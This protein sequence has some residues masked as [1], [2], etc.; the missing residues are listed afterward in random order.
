MTS[1]RMNYRSRRKMTFS[2]QRQLSR[3]ANQK[4]LE[5]MINILNYAGKII[6]ENMLQSVLSFLSISQKKKLMNKCV[7]IAEKHRMDKEKIFCDYLDGSETLDESIA[8]AFKNTNFKKIIYNDITN[9]L[10]KLHD[11]IKP[12]QDNDSL[13]K[14]LEH[15]AEIFNLSPAET[16]L[17]LFLYIRDHHRTVDRAFDEFCEFLDI[18][19]Y[20]NYIKNP[21]SLSIVTG[22]EKNLISKAISSSSNMEK[23]GVIN[24]DKELAGEINQFLHGNSHKPMTQKYFTEYSKS[25]IP[26]EYHTIDKKHIQ[27]VKMLL[28]HKSPTQ[29][30]NI[31]LYGKPGT[32][33]S[34]FSRSLGKH[35][36][37]N[38]YEI[39]NI[40]DESWDDITM[41]RY[42]ALM[43]CQRMVPRE[44]S[45]I[46]VDEADAI[47]NSTPAFFSMAPVAEKGQ[48]NKLLDES[49]AFII[50]I[51]NR[52][53]GIDESTKRRFDY[54]IGF[55]KLTFR[56]R[57]TIW[58]H[59]IKK[60]RMVRCFSQ[61]DIDHL[62]NRYEISAG[63]IEIALRNASRIYRKKRS[64]EGILDVI[65]TILKAHLKILD[66]EEEYAK[67]PDNG[68]YSLDGLSIKG[69]IQRTITHIDRF[70]I[71]WAMFSDS[72]LDASNLNMLLYGPPGTGKT[73]F[74]KFVARRMNRR[75]IIKR[76]SDLIN[77]YLGETE[78]L[79]KKVFT[80]AEKDKAILFIDEADSLFGNREN[81]VRSWEITQVNEMLTC[82]ERLNGMLICATNFKQIVDSAAIRRFTIKLEFD[83]LKPEGAVKFYNRFFENIIDSPLTKSEKKELGTLQCLT[84]GDFKIVK[85][86]YYFFDEKKIPNKEL[87][88]ALRQETMSKNGNEGKKI[89]FGK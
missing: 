23:T 60:H 43:A 52:Y 44:Q 61:S 79:I 32:G 72:M 63:G 41:F 74:A 31:L 46:V 7:H 47:L 59:S 67:S 1:Y 69:D 51:T 10:I 28:E 9:T 27:T 4:K 38:V 33:K 8:R 18:S 76:A 16:E 34:E 13:Q 26:L 82:M 25:A 20:H 66:M 14:K 29:G 42:R 6:G 49:T 5:Y 89:G 54:S 35:L 57:R 24:E 39:N 11:R 71:Y 45:V 87:I 17:I 65:D 56:Q 53:S 64:K 80:E 21:R 50:W 40:S 68:I 86:T 58:L 77:M 78:K 3:L 70:N 83:Y 19:H 22:V 2:P 30:M 62:A 36:G 75:L 37:L 85:Q 81:A 84:P 15:I 48:I 88:D 73:E 12:A 55:E